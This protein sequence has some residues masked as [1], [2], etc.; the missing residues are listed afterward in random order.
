MIIGFGRRMRE[1]EELKRQLEEEQARL[2][3]EMDSLIARLE[4]HD[5]H[6]PDVAEALQDAVLFLLKNLRRS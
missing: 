1:R 5:P 4:H 6:E 2:S 3:A